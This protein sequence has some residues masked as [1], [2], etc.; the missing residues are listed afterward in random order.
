MT[1]IPTTEIEETRSRLWIAQKRSGLTYEEIA[2]K[3]NINK[4]WLSDFSCRPSCSPLYKNVRRLQITLDVLDREES[5][6]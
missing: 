3:A 6:S 1:D 5:E 4:G 2:V